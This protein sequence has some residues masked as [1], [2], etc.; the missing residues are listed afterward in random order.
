[1]VLELYKF[2][3]D[4]M[5][6]EVRGE[7]FQVGSS[8]AISNVKNTLVAIQDAINKL[9]TTNLFMKSSSHVD[10]SNAL[11]AAAIFKD[12]YEKRF[13]EYVDKAI[14]NDK[15]SAARFNAHLDKQLAMD[16]QIANLY[17]SVDKLQLLTR[18]EMMNNDLS[19]TNMSVA[20]G[21]IVLLCS[22]LFSFIYSNKIASPIINLSD[23]VDKFTKS[24]FSTM[25]ISPSRKA[26]DEFKTL[27]SN[28][29]IMGVKIQETLEELRRSNERLKASNAHL[30][31]FA[32]IV[33]HDLRAPLR[34][35][36]SFLGLL[37]RRINDK[38]DPKDREYLG[39]VQEGAL[40]LNQLIKD[41]LEF[42]KV[43]TQSINLKE[44]NLQKILQEVLEFNDFQLNERAVDLV[45]NNELDVILCDSIKVKQI[46]QNL[47]TN[48]IKYTK[49]DQQPK[50]IINCTEEKEHWKFEVRD[51]GIGIPE[52]DHARI[53]L[54]FSQLK[55]LHGTE[56]IGIGLSICKTYIELH[57][58]K[59]WV[60]SHPIGSSLH[61]TLSKTPQPVDVTGEKVLEIAEV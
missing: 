44:K 40:K 46:F 18:N 53:F 11:V 17:H 37:Q 48:A 23:K 13:D 28:I 7:N 8:P 30:Q 33:S 55:N 43:D 35:I 42:S 24:G 27:Q 56:G 4:L 36:H 47:I 60:E 32:H 14:S 38:M 45:I 41:I 57:G 20:L 54:P 59:I 21:C 1:M 5:T 10:F 61:F 51:E 2:E 34:T 52:K 19:F 31:R 29:Y 26:T 6:Y 50:V 15:I 3:N 39:F 58:G 12:D 9:S 16:E 25:A 22:I 49:A